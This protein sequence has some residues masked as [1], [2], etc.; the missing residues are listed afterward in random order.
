MK[1]NKATLS[2]MTMLDGL[3]VA[4][5]YGGIQRFKQKF[6]ASWEIYWAGLLN[7]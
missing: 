2:F 6:K 5:I 4:L 3:L 7:S 1:A